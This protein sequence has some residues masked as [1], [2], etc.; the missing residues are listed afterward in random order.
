MISGE[1]EEPPAVM[2]GAE[3]CR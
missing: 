3:A 1:N 2:V